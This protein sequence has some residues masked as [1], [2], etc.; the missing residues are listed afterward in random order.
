[1]LHGKS[2]RLADAI[3]IN[4][5]Q[6]YF[7][8]RI[9]HVVL[10]RRIARPIAAGRI[11]FNDHQL[12]RWEGG[13]DDINDLARSISAA[14]QAAGYVAWRNQFRLQ[15]GF[16]WR[17]TFRDLASCL[18]GED[19]FVS[20][21]QI[22]GIRQAVKHIL[23]FANRDGALAPIHLAISAQQDKSCFFAVGAR[24]K[25]VTRLQT[26]DKK[27]HPVPSRLL[28]GQRKKF[29]RGPRWQFLGVYEKASLAQVFSSAGGSNRACPREH[30]ICLTAL[31]LW[32][33]NARLS[34]VSIFRAGSAWL[35]R[36]NPHEHTSHA[37]SLLSGSMA[38]RQV[39]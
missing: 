16:G 8:G 31:R 17:A 14:A 30:C 23:A 13:R 15:A 21:G 39:R 7:A 6:I 34:I 22:Q 25:D 33:R 18:G 29:T 3:V 20:G 12:I 2:F 9:V 1:M 4:L 27:T 24:A 36:N 11:N 26:A 37:V 32:Q 10:V 35:E 5:I 19:R 38:R 28:P